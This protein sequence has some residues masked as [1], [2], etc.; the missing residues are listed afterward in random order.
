MDG[1]I[2]GRPSTRIFEIITWS[3]S[4]YLTTIEIH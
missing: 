2:K 3:S 4:S 1:E